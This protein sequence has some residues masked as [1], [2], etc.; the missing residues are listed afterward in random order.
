MLRA[1]DL[2]PIYAQVRPSPLAEAFFLQRLVALIVLQFQGS[3]S[4]DE[5]RREAGNVAVSLM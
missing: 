5:R 3:R 4:I 2:A 1:K